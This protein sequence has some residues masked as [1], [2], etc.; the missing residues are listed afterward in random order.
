MVWC[1]VGFVMCACMLDLGVVKLGV[2]VCESAC[3]CVVVLVVCGVVRVFGKVGCP[4]VVVCCSKVFVVCCLF[5][6][7]SVRWG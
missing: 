4:F 7:V 2:V 1:G 6:C 3:S 5:L